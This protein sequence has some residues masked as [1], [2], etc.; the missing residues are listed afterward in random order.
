MLQLPPAPVCLPCLRGFEGWDC[1]CQLWTWISIQEPPTPPP[2]PLIPDSLPLSYDNGP[3]SMAGMMKMPV[4]LS[5]RGSLAVRREMSQK[6]NKNLFEGLSCRGLWTLVCLWILGSYFLNP[7]AWTLQLSVRWT[8]LPSWEE[9]RMRQELVVPPVQYM[10]VRV[11]A[12]AECQ[13]A[14]PN[15]GHRIWKRLKLDGTNSCSWLLRR[16][17]GVQ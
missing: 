15:G 6:S 9:P 13:T 2:P 16:H 3:I 8:S 10:R 5:Q 11:G 7:G 4:G 12:E 17:S 14:G 1:Y